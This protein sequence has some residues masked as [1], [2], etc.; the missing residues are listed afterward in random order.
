MTRDDDARTGEAP[1]RS[2]LK[3]DAEARQVLGE[4]LSELPDKVLETLGLPD[5]LLTSI[6]RIRHM[7]RGGGLRRERQRIGK[8]MRKVDIEPV[9]ATLKAIEADKRR[10]TRRFHRIEQLRDR[11][12][13]DDAEAVR[14]LEAATDADTVRE[15]DQLARHAREEEI[16]GQPP[17][18]A[19][20]LFRLLREA[21]DEK[22]EQ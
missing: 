4:R 9:E 18:A 6:Q 5:E 17:A 22:S 12:L 1:S 11:L 19:R 16:R 15:A 8:L 3:R 20:A 14:E 7:R 13:A 21:L 10:E 2:R